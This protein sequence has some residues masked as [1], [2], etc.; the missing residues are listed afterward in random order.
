MLGFLHLVNGPL[1][2]F[3]QLARPISLIRLST[4]L[5]DELLELGV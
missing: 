3:F 5:S 2:P 1:Y 4:L